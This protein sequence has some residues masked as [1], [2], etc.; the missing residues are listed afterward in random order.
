MNAWVVRGLGMALIHVVLR[1]LLGIAITQWPLQGSAFRMIALVL[2]IIAAL[3]WGWFDATRDRKKNPD[4]EH[5]AD[6]TMRW[7]KA[8]ILG[9]L[10]AGLGTWLADF[11]VT[12]T[13]NPLFFELTSGAAFTVL[14][15]FVPAM[16]AVMVARLVQNRKESN[17]SDDTETSDPA[18]AATAASAAS[19][20]ADSG[21]GT[22]VLS[23]DQQHQR[24]PYAQEYTGQDYTGSDYNADDPDAD[25]TVFDAVSDPGNAPKSD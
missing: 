17:D 4:P 15:I 10:L 3:L 21:L 8:A 13:E 25:T 6:L 5:G 11:V 16:L 7:L 20:E 19:A 1:S 2:V 9:G 23:L 18:Y 22:E 12:A 24:D 14:L